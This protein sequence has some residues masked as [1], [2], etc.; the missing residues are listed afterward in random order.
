MAI[1]ILAINILQYISGAIYF[2]ERLKI[3]FFGIF[4]FSVLVYFLSKKNIMFTVLAASVASNV[5]LFYDVN[6]IYYYRW[7][8]SSV[9]N[10]WP[11]INI[12]ALITLVVFYF[13]NRNLNEDNI[14]K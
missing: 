1:N 3:L 11:W 14:K 8:V 5:V 2:S 12:I 13:K 4:I 6:N 10:I 9:K 7:V